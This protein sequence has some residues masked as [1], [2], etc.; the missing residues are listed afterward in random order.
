M[1]GIRAFPYTMALVSPNYVEHAGRILASRAIH[2]ISEVRDPGLGGRIS[3]SIR[4]LALQEITSAFTN[5][6]VS[7]SI[8]GRERRRWYFIVRDNAKKSKHIFHQTG[9]IML[10]RTRA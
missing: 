10:S 7:E 1:V 9:N 4:P 5:S 3:S 8:L 6:P 2:T